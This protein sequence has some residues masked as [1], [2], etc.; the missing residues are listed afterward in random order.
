[1]SDVRIAKAQA[2]QNMA[3]EIG[4]LGLHMGDDAKAKGAGLVHFSALT[5][6]NRGMVSRLS[7]YEDE[8]FM[9]TIS[10]PN[11]FDFSFVVGDITADPETGV[12]TLKGTKSI[13]SVRLV[14]MPDVIK[15]H[16]PSLTTTA[17]RI[18]GQR[19]SLHK[20]QHTGAPTVSFFN[21]HYDERALRAVSS[22]HDVTK[23]RF[24][25]IYH[26]EGVFK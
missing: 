6:E 4:L 24:E 9:M 10:Q 13:E 26:S 8:A 1:M 23:L 22:K 15:M 20:L 19:A 16:R 14:K 12:F 2:L 7:G 5:R 3:A 21:C 18:I 17:D 11:G 25:S